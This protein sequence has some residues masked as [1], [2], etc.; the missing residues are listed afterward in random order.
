MQRLARL[1]VTFLL[2]IA[3]PMQGMAATT[4]ISCGSGPHPHGQA[5]TD[6]PEHHGDVAGHWHSHAA[7][8]SSPVTEVDHGHGG[9]SDLAKGTLHKCSACA[10]CCT[11]V[12]VPSHTVAFDSVKLTD[13][14]SPLAARSVPAYVSEGLERPPRAF[15]A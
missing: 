8:A 12:A 9:K 3:L 13:Q 7:E 1:A 15:L 5:Q 6:S 2:A 4:M 11:G 10:S 14:F